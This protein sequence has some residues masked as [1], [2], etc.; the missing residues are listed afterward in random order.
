MNQFLKKIPKALWMPAAIASIVSG[1]SIGIKEMGLLESVEL[2]AYDQAVRLQGAEPKDKRVLVIG[3]GT[4]DIAKYGD[5]TYSVKD[6]TLN[7][8]LKKLTDGGAAAIGVDLFRSSATGDL[9]KTLQDPDNIVT[10][11]CAHG[12]KGQEPEAGPPQ[13]KAE[14]GEPEGEQV[15]KIGF[16][17][18]PVDADGITRRTSLIAY[19]RDAKVCPAQSSLS[20]R[21]A[22]D[23]LRE[24]HKIEPQLND[25][26]GVYSLGKLNIPQLQ[27]N[28]GGYQKQLKDDN[29][30]VVSGYPIMLKY[31]HP[32]AIEVVSL[33]DLM[34]N[35]VTNLQDRI[36]L[37]GATASSKKDE[38]RTPYSAGL[39]EH[40]IMY[41]VVVHAQAASQIVSM[42]LD[43]RSQ[44]GFWPQGLENLLLVGFG[45]MGGYVA[46]FL[47]HPAKL[48]IGLI[49]AVAVPIGLF[50]VSLGNALWIPVIS[51]VLAL[52]GTALATGTWRAYQTNQE[53]QNMRQLAN[54]QQQTIDALKQLLS[55]QP[56]ASM[57]ASNAPT[58]PYKVESN[59]I[60]GGRYQT[61]G[62]LGSGGFATTY[63]AEDINMPGRPRCA[64]KHLTPARRD[65]AFVDVSRRLFSTEAKILERLG[66][67]PQIP[68]LLA[69]F[70]QNDEFYLV[71]ELIDG[72]PLDLELEECKEPWSQTKVVDLLKQMLPVLDYIHGQSVIHRDIKPSNI[73]RCKDGG[74]MVLID[75]GAVKEINPQAVNQSIAIGTKGYTPPEQYMGRPNFS[76]DIYALGMVAIEAATNT[77]P[78]ELDRPT[79]DDILQ[80]RHLAPLQPALANVLD[81]MV[82]YQYGNRYKSASEVLKDLQAFL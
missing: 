48:S 1:V 69:Y 29:E 32:S 41:G 51:P 17:D 22:E 28:D 50:G 23:Y 16:A 20:L 49:A 12:A 13:P 27:A 61:T 66:S 62:T 2:L 31:R 38:F 55:Q 44:I 68:Q 19:P 67:H 36:V 43:G 46:W 59:T 75:F 21:L 80:W 76:S 45:L 82:A 70:E 11:I 71:Q 8:A 58:V 47:R 40:N 6:G 26:T 14:E 53:Q 9:L 52:L 65:P 10:P 39:A 24:K 64:I 5:K 81:K 34:E 7:T 79:T 3:V 35:R 4:K 18:I 37:I 77:S 60:L 56:A 42:A 25:K 33:D 78:L 63:A 57:N 30:K 74:K 15:V 73:I 72:R 54:N